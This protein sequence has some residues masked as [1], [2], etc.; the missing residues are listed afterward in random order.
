MV[1]YFPGMDKQLRAIAW[2][3]SGGLVFLRFYQSWSGTSP[4]PTPLATITFPTIGWQQFEAFTAPEGEADPDDNT[5][6]PVQ[7][8]VTQA[9]MAHWRWWRPNN[10]VNINSLRP[11]DTG[12]TTWVIDRAL[13]FATYNNNDTGQAASGTRE[14]VEQLLYEAWV[15]FIATIDPGIVIIRENFR[16]R[17]ADHLVLLPF[18]HN[19]PTPDPPDPVFFQVADANGWLYHEEPGGVGDPTY[20][21]IS[22]ATIILNIGKILKSLPADP[23]TGQKPETYTF[24]VDAPAKSGDGTMVWGLTGA[25]YKFSDRHTFPVSD[26]TG[27]DGSLVDALSPTWETWSTEQASAGGADPQGGSYALGKITFARAGQKP[28]LEFENFFNSPTEG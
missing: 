27:P 16:V 28:K 2:G 20:G 13:W 11:G 23:V 19:E 6:A 12:G 14:E 10:P 25:A 17:L 4:A 22:V 26:T 9:M 18:P 5:P 8:P 1:D 7:D 21:R 3:S 15:E 24:R